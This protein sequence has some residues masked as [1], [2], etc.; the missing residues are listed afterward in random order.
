MITLILITI[1]T[2]YALFLRHIYKD[3]SK[4]KEKI[5]I[6]KI[7]SAE[8]KYNYNGNINERD[9]TSLIITLAQN[10]YLKINKKDNFRLVKLK[11]YKGKNK[12]EE[13]LFSS[14]FSDSNVVP[15]NELHKKLYMK[16]S[17]VVHSIDTKEQRKE[18]NQKEELLL[19]N[20]L[21]LLTLIIF[22]MI[23]LKLNENI[24]KEI[25]ITF[26][27][28]TSFVSLIRV[29]TSKNSK[30]SKIVVTI[31]TSF[32]SLP[33]YLYTFFKLINNPINLLIYILGHI[34]V[35]IIINTLSYLTPKTFAGLELK[36]EAEDYN[37]FL[38]NCTKEQIEKILKVNPK[39]LEQTFSYAYAFNHSFK[40][41][42]LMKKYNKK[43]KWFE[44][45]EIEFSENLLKIKNQI[46]KA[47]H[48]ED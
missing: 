4:T 19:N 25:F 38:T 14:I 15:I 9:L 40:W 33:F 45:T 35:A 36:E 39:Y 3:T 37:N 11:N 32:L 47:G 28:W 48:K 20:N 6:P 41:R 21:V 43:L 1:F 13:L 2:L 24:F 29:F 18:N 30:R 27:T 22:F 42:R 31:L 46:L 5:T 44:G 16:I 12:S 23:T 10:G 26:I 17:D 7:T 8:L 34:S